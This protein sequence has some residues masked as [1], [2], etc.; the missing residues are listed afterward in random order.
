[1]DPA[2]HYQDFHLGE[3]HQPH[4]EATSIIET[5]KEA[6]AKYQGLTMDMGATIQ[7]RFQA[8]IYRE[9][10]SEE[11]LSKST[12]KMIK[13]AEKGSAVGMLTLLMN[14]KSHSINHGTPTYFF[15]E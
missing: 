12:K 2:V 11:Q 15:A 9:D 14:L 10:F 13:T 4:A 5:L 7:P 3:E 1:M 8:N 6:G